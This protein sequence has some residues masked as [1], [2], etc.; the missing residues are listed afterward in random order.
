[1]VAE[2]LV[3]T[4]TNVCGIAL[5]KTLIIFVFTLPFCIFLCLSLSMVVR[6]Q[7]ARWAALLQDL[8]HPSMVLFQAALLH[9]L[10]KTPCWVTS[11]P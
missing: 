1:M 4:I 7:G 11:L 2:M 6:C 9:L 5:F 8:S 3:N 10:P